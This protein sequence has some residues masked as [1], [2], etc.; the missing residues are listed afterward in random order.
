[1]DFPIVSLLDDDLCTSWLLKYLHATGLKCPHCEAV[2]DEARVFRQTTR[3]QLC[4]YRCQACQGIYTLYSGTVFA[5]RHLHPAQAVLLL[6]GV[7]QGQ[8]TAHLAREIH[9]SRKTVHDIRH[10]I[11]ANVEREQP[12][13][14]LK[15]KRTETDELFQNA[16]EKRR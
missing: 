5:G 2:V 14:P 7:C 6:R 1:M 10:A 12:N 3:G 11:Q 4:V 8:P 13:T 9:L 15:D 16:G